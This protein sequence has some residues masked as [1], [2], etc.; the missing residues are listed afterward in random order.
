MTKTAQ[1]INLVVYKYRRYVLDLPK[2]K[3]IE[4]ATVYVEN[5]ANRQIKGLRPSVAIC[6]ETERER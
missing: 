3:A 6:E 5:D 2:A 4:L 1:V